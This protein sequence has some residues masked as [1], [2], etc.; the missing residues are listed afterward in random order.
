MATNSSKQQRT[1]KSYKIKCKAL[2]ELEKGTTD[3]ESQT[4]APN[5]IFKCAEIHLPHKKWQ[6]VVKLTELPTIQTLYNSNKFS[7]PLKVRIIES[8]L[9]DLLL[10]PCIRGVN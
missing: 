8:L 2:N 10:P 5:N 1:D 3:K 7:I 9:Y 4:R 6:N